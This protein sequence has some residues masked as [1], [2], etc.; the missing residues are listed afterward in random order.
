M[1]LNVIEP[2]RL[3]QVV[4]D[5][6]AAVINADEYRPGDRLPTER[7][8]ARQLGVSRPIIRE[9]MIA[10]EI[11]GLVDVRGGSGAYVRSHRAP[12]PPPEPDSAEIGPFD[13][14]AARLAVEGT[15][16]ALAA[17][18]A[19]EDDLAVM[20]EAIEEMRLAALDGRS[21]TA[22]NQRFHMTLAHAAQNP[23]LLKMVETI[24]AEVPRRGKLWA[25]LDARRQMRPSRVSEH[26][27]IL[28][29]VAERNPERAYAATRA[30]L[31]A[32]IKDYLNEAPPVF[33]DALL[34]NAQEANR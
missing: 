32:A 29:A 16:A 14:F 11:A 9:A 15:I 2:K 23:M 20:A 3:Y 22:A 31:Q 19:T 10:L 12:E 21:T 24:W 28:R 30:H 4:A 13:I 33:T 25:K 34:P 7:E 5:Q 1:P 18:S 26:A 17:E 27:L 6:I 8:L